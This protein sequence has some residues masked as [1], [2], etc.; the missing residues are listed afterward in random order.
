M[1]SFVKTTFRHLFRSR[2]G[3]VV[4]VLFILGLTATAMANVYVFYYSNGTA[5]V[6]TPDVRLVKGADLQSS[7]SAYPCASGS[8]TSTYDV[9][10]ATLSFFPASTGASPPPATYYSNF[11]KITNAGTGSHTIETIQVTSV[12][13]TSADLGSITVYYCTSQ[14]EFSAS[15]SPVSACTGSFAIT[16]TSGGTVFSGTQSIAS[17]A[18]Q[19]I[20]IAAYAASG[21]SASTSVTFQIAVQWV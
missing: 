15:G 5:T 4:A 16:T 14:T 20:E 13:G 19:Y 6:Q 21:A 18:T 2:V 3:K 9:M 11:A 12:G 8:V 10:T 7:C 17:G 1:I